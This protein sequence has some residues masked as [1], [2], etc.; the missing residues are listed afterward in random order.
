[1]PSGIPPELQLILRVQTFVFLGGG[2]LICAATIL[3]FIRT[4]T[5]PALVMLLAVVIGLSGQAV[6]YFSPR[7][8]I[9]YEP[10]PEPIEQGSLPR[11]SDSPPGY[12][13]AERTR[14]LWETPAFWLAISGVILWVGG[15]VAHSVSVARKDS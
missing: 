9:A 12:R 3:L 8:A 1:M 4:R 6:G 5:K 15:F 14:D 7:E 13:R 2:I 11:V 10:D